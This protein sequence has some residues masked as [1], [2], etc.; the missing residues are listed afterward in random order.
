[1]TDL[2]NVYRQ[3]IEEGAPSRAGITEA[4]GPERRRMDALGYRVSEVPII[5]FY[6]VLAW[7]RAG[8]RVPSVLRIAP[9]ERHCGASCESHDEPDRWYRGR[10]PRRPFLITGLRLTLRSVRG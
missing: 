5:A 8:Y 7:A 10:S 3:V 6:R 4:G 9:A 2:V 1:M